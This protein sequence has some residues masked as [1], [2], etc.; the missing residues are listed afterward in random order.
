MRVST[1]DIG[2]PQRKMAL[3]YHIHREHSEGIMNERDIP[4]PED[5]F[6]EGCFYEKDEG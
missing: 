1:E 5:F 2:V 3:P 6:R 4:D